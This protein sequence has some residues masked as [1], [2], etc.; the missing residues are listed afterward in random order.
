MYMLPARATASRAGHLADR[1]GLAQALHETEPPGLKLLRERLLFLGRGD[2]RGL[3][4]EVA[5]LV[6]ADLQAKL[7]RGAAKA[8]QIVLQDPDFL[9]ELGV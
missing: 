5:R 2:R 7:R 9:A 1:S 4:R 6:L 8:S 3:V